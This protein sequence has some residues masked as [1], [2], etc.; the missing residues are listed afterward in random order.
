[1]AWTFLQPNS[2]MSNTFGWIAQLRS[3]EVVRLPFADVRVAAID[4]D[5]LGVVAAIVP[6]SNEHAGRAYRWSGPESLLPQDQVR[7][8]AKVLGRDL[9]FQAPVVR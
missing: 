8:L 6:T 5:N 1:M 2:F 3:S 7:I 4:P 9:R